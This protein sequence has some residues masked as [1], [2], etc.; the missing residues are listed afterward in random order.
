MCPASAVAFLEWLDMVQYAD[1]DMSGEMHMDGR[2]DAKMRYSA[3]YP[4]G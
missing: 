4:T 1:E 2:Q 3:A